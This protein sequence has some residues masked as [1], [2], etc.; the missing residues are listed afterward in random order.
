MWS[1]HNTR[2]RERVGKRQRE[3]RTSK[4]LNTLPNHLKYMINA[5][6]ALTVKSLL[7][8]ECCHRCVG[9]LDFY[10]ILSKDT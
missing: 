5:H 10:L 1:C 8:P 3:V 7:T 4:V 6:S 2:Q 9:S